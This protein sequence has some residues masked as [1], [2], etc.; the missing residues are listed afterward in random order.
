MSTNVWFNNYKNKN[1]QNLVDDLVIESIQIY[2][3]DTF[4]VTRNI[5]NVDRM[6]NEDRVS[7]F[8]AAYNTE[9]YISSVDGFGGEGDFLSKFGLQI[10][11]QVTF[12]IAVRTFERNVI[13]LTPSII[14]P[15][16]GDL[17]YMPHAQ[18]FFKIMHVEH[19]SVFYQMG[20]LQV[21]ELQCELF[22]YSNERFATGIDDIDNHYKWYKTD[23]SFLPDLSLES[24]RDTDVPSRNLDYKEET[25]DII[26]FSQLDPFTETEIFPPSD[27]DATADDINTTVDNN[28]YTVDLDDDSED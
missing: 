25:D 27:Y 9:M 5:Q 8:N 15:N 18:E 12:V 11:D 4:Y 22:E 6:F 28:V 26:D 3:I 13:R 17:V 10:R 24:L 14:R 16:E 19:E 1:E 23:D 2:G 7:V 20:A 21:Y